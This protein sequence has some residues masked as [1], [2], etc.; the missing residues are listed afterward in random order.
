VGFEDFMAVTTK[1]AVF[2]D[3]AERVASIF[4]VEALK[5]LP[6]NCSQSVSNRLTLFLARVL[7]YPEDGG[8]TFLRNVSLY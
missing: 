4:R 5:A 3:V 7:F 2:W 1:T 8:D 6:P